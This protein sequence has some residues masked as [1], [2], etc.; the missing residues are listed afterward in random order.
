MTARRHTVVC[1]DDH[2]RAAHAHRGDCAR[3]GV[4]GQYALIIGSI[5]EAAQRSVR[6]HACDL[7]PALAQ[8]QHD[9]LLLRADRL[10]GRKHR[11]R[12]RA[13][14]AVQRRHLQ[15]RASHLMRR[16]DARVR[17]DRRDFRI[18]GL[19][20]AGAVGRACIE[21]HR[22]LA[23][24]PRAKRHR[25]AGESDRGRLCIYRHLAGGLHAVVGSG[26]DRHRAGL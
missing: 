19:E 11:H 14:L 1:R 24:V 6:I 23:A 26:R 25:L 8:A 15:R 9:F 20:G 13:A 18:A 3:R 16:H 21:L 7:S 10:R 4:H 22:D 5:G 2:V 12:A 17:V